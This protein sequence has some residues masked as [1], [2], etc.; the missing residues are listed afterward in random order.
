MKSNKPILTS[1]L[2]FAHQICAEAALY[3][4]PISEYDIAD[5]IELLM[6]NNSLQEHLI[7]EGQQQLLKLET[8]ESRA[9]KLMR[10]IEQSCG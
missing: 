4:D 1:D 6:S 9:D 5:K 10:L 7:A 8:P 2:D 3:F